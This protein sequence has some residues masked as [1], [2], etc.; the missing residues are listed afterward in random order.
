LL[1]FKLPEELV[2]CTTRSTRIHV[3]DK[4]FSF[5]HDSP[6]V[7]MTSR[8]SFD[9]FLTD[10]AVEAGAELRDHSPVHQINATQSQVEVKTS[11]GTFE[12]KIV[13]GADG[14]GDP[15]AEPAPYA[16]R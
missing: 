13:I 5:E 12:S 7:Y 14:M 16:D 9:G 2:E 3:G 10:K 15:T 4:C 1:D 8:A 11:Q 6:L